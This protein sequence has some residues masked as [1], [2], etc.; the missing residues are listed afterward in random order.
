MLLAI[1]FGVMVLLNVLSSVGNVMFFHKTNAEIS[2]AYPTVITPAGFTFSVWGIIYTFVGLYVVYNLVPSLRQRTGSALL[3][4]LAVLQIA[5]FAF[6]SAWLVA[7]SNSQLWLGVFLI[8]GYAVV[9]ARAYL[10]LGVGLRRAWWLEKVAVHCAVSSNLSWVLVANCANLTLVLSANGWS[11]PAEWGSAW[12]A[13][14]GALAVYVA[15]SRADITYVAVFVWA[16]FGVASKHN[17]DAERGV[18]NACVA[19]AVVSTVALLCGLLLERAGGYDARGNKQT[20]FNRLLGST[21]SD[22]HEL[23]EEE[24]AAPLQHSSSAS[25]MVEQTTQ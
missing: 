3:R 12:V 22:Y 20:A 6:N 16:C 21:M 18:F 8:A 2:N 23:V 17:N 4:P 10:L 14:L 1:A 7:F 15:L 19:A 9:L 25:R 11:A 5:G 24:N 13:A